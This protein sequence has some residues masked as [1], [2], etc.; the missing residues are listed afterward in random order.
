MQ[1]LP[2]QQTHKEGAGWKCKGCGRSSHP[3]GKSMR[4]C[5]CP[6]FNQNCRACGIKG[7]F[8]S[9][10]Q[11]SKTAA[12]SSTNDDHEYS[13]ENQI[14]TSSTSSSFAFA[15]CDQPQDFHATQG[16]NKRK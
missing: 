16:E 9:V 4:R 10:C 1:T 14:T 13:E 7:H 11:Q 15:V 8:M 3:K 2:N 5:D 12:M 6:A